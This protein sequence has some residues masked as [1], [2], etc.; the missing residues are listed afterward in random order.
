M[1]FSELRFWYLLLGGLTVIGLLRFFWSKSPAL[2]L[3]LFDRVMLGCLGLFLLL[4]VSWLTFLIF[5]AVVFVTYFGLLVTVRFFNGSRYGLLFIVPLQLAALIYYKY[6]WFIGHEWLGLNV[7][8]LKDL[9][10]PVGISF[11]SFQLVS[12]AVDT[13]VLKKPLPPF[14]DCLNFIVFFPQIVAGPIERRE[15]LLP[16]MEKFRFRFLPHQIEEGATWIVAGLFLKCV[17]ADNLAE[18]FDRSST[19]N[20]FLIWKANLLFALRIYYDFAG[21]SLIAVGLGKCLGVNLTLNF[22]SPYCA[23]SVGEFWRRWHI[24]LSQWFRD[25]VYFPLGGARV[26]WWAFNLFLVFTVSGIWHGAGWNFLIWGFAHGLFLVAS[27]IFKMKWK[28]AIV[29]W[30]LTQFVVLFTWLF[31]YETRPAA[32]A[33]KTAALCLPSAYTLANFKAFVAESASKH[34]LVLFA[35]LSLA[36][37]T[38]LGEWLSLKKGGEPYVYLR[39]RGFV[40]LMVI[41]IVFLTPGIANDFIYFAF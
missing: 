4:A 19:D 15:D 41:A 27:R 13:L 21:Y 16:Q 3:S 9:L 29:S 6:S 25:Y 31:F 37:I 18:H 20:P 33:K 36:A 35:F 5:A 32:L 1:N 24:T 34:T 26:R 8:H 23:T 22:Q 12:F 38:L 2:S 39:K 28:P 17:L 14:I 30:L 11:Y 40:V 7:P 10:I